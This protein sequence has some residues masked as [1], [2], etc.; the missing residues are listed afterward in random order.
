MG[1]QAISLLHA[2]LRAKSLTPPPP[3]PKFLLVPRLAAV[4]NCL[5]GREV[6]D[7]VLEG[8]AEAYSRA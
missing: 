8:K 1:G 5:C 6:G 7:Q 3:M 2:R 4:T